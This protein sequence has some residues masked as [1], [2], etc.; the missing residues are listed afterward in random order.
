MART[1]EYW[2]NKKVL[3]TGATGFIGRHLVKRLVDEGADV[4]VFVLDEES[5]TIL[6]QTKVP[7]YRGN[8]VNLND[9]HRCVVRFQ[10]EYVFHLAAQPL[11]D[12]ALKGVLDTLDSNITGGRNLLHS[13]LDAASLRSI[14]FVSTDK[15]YGRT[16]NAS[17]MDALRGVHHPYNASKVCADVLAQMYG[18]VFDMPIVIIRSGNVY[19]GGDLNFDRLI[20]YSVRQALRGDTVVLRSDGEYLRDYIYI[21]DMIDGYLLAA[22][23]QGRH[24]IPINFGAEKPVSVNE[25][26][27]TV[28]SHADKTIF[29]EIEN[30]AKHE[31]P[32]QHLNWGLARNIGWHPQVSFGEGI[33]K[34]YE[35]YKEYFNG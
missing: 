26:V 33:K 2:K 9:I 17:E 8:L 28:L 34:T 27:S 35:W 32:F 23:T 20:P 13:C 25:V 24:C 7:I 30:T 5:G 6:W 18:S 29:V 16:D 21:D 19:G 31:I 3:V 12:T 15:V 10:P 14:V 1:S 22:K 4:A 11:V